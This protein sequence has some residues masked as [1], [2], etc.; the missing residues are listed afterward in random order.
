MSKWFSILLVILVIV[1]GLIGGA[2]SEHI[3]SPKLAVAEGANQNNVLTVNELRVMDKNGNAGIAMIVDENGGRLNVFRKIDK[4]VGASIGIDEYGNGDINLLA[5]DGYG[6][7]HPPTITKVDPI[8]VSS[9]GG[10]EITI[11]GT[12]FRTRQ[13]PTVT[14][15]GAPAIGA[16]VVSETLLRARVPPGIAGPADIVV[17]Y[18]KSK[19]KSMPFKGFQ[20]FDEVMVSATE[21]DPMMFGSEGIDA[22]SK[23]TVTFNQNVEA[24]SVIIWIT[25]I[26]GNRIAGIINQ[27]VSNPK[28]FTFS[29]FSLLKSGTYTV[30]VGGA[31]SIGSGMA[32]PCDFT[33]SFTVK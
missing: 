7:D 16:K 11:I 32:M 33:F 22:P 28:K 25:D 19:V 4:K 9:A 3:F 12:D 8:I 2:I 20:Y 30:T 27:D 23:I 18:V 14:V 31:Q 26:R 1:S 6:S 10:T 24:T 5:D 21:P 13:V 29:P 15:G 17:H